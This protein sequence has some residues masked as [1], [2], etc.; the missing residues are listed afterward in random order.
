M[1][2]T[3]SYGASTDVSVVASIVTVLPSQTTP[4]PRCSRT[5]PMVK[6]SWIR[7]TLRSTV[8]PGASSAAAISLRAEFLAPETTTA[9][10]RRAPPVT[11]RR[12]MRASV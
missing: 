8:R 1:R 9:P 2:R 4:A 7:G 6:Q 11:R 10:S 12:S 5:S 3:S